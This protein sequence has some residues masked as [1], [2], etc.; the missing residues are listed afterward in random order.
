[1]QQNDSLW[2]DN[3][4][5]EN[6]F[7]CDEI[8]GNTVTLNNLLLLTDKYSTV[9]Q[10]KGSFAT[11]ISSEIWFNCSVH[12]KTCFPNAYDDYVDQLIL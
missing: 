4:N 3:D 9:M 1:M 11:F 6:C 7:M 8:H 2:L 10:I 12:S 5:Q